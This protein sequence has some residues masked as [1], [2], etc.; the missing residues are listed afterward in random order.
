MTI[1]HERGTL[2]SL[3]R[4]QPFQVRCIESFFRSYGEGRIYTR[5]VNGTL[6]LDGVSITCNGYDAVWEELT[7]I[8]INLEDYL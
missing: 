3:E 7:P 6:T 5:E 8:E 2:P 1:I 4:D